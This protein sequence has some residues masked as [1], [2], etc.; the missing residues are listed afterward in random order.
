MRG[1]SRALTLL[2]CVFVVGACNREAPSGFRVVRA[3]HHIFGTSAYPLA[4]APSLV[5]TYPPNSDSGA[6]YF[7]DQVLEYRV[8]LHPDKGAQPLNGDKDYFVAFAQYEPAE[9]F[10]RK[11]P[12][13]E[14][15]LVLVR[16]FEWINEPERGHYVPEKGNRVT[17]W[18]VKWLRNNMR[19]PNSISEFM[20]HP[21]EEGP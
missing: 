19:A 3:D 11:T 9:A 15:P 4:V 14:A 17:E 12:G 6:G 8:W 18:Q 5:G 1:R 2:A 10:S 21:T 7:Y 16:Q 13:A 20:K